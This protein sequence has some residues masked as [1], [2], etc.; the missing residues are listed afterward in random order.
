MLGL[1]AIVPLLD[2][3]RA[4]GPTTS[5][6]LAHGAALDAL[7]VIRS[8]ED[9]LHVDAGGMDL[10]GIKFADFNQLFHFR[11][12]DLA[13]AGDHGA[14]V[15]GRLAIDEIAPLIALPRLYQCELR[16]DA[17][18]HHVHPAVEI[19]GFFA[20]GDDGAVASG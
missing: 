16:R 12:R 18:L 19:L 9:A 5:Y 10:V 11:D 4:A 15:A 2:R 1:L 8:L 3:L 14:E 7:L 20:L 17:A 6:L 13:S